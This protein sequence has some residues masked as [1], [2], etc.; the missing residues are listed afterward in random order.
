LP[1]RPKLAAPLRAWSGI[2]R[3]ARIF[4]VP[5][6]FA[7]NVLIYDPRVFEKPPDSWNALWD[8][9]LSGKIALPDDVA[10][11]WMIAQSLGLDKADDRAHLFDLSDDELTR[12]KEKYARVK[13]NIR[14]LWQRSGELVQMLREHEIVAALGYPLHVAALRQQNVAVEAVIPKEGTTGWADYWMIPQN[15]ANVRAAYVW[16][17]F[18]SQPFAQKLIADKV[19]QSIAN[20]QAASYFT[21]EQVRELHLDALDRYAAQIKFAWWST[22]RDAW[23]QI[24]TAPN[25][26]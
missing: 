20:S 13:P 15:A 18:A 22:R 24:K 11:V 4:G 12:V 16:I 19:A 10:T 17:E 14:V 21:P 23:A 7:P 6:A 8:P 5:I 3:E 26:P 25:Q 1:T 2:E 9:N